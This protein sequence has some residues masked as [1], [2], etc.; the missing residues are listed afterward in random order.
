APAGRPAPAGGAASMSHALPQPARFCPRC[1]TEI[2]APP[3]G[4]PPR[5]PRG[6]FTWWPDPKV[7]T[8]VVVERDGR[9]LLVRRNHE[10]AMGEWSFPSGFVDAGEVV[11]A[12]AARE[13]WEETG[14]GVRL[15]GL[16]GVYSEAGDP[17]I[18]VAYAG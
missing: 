7:A 15:E 3:E 2:P 17:V 14:L 16:L 8:G 13:V 18:F 5:C 9:I 10:P 11:E 12:A 4:E 6:D 1:A